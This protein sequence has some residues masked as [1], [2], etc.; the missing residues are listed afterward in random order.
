MNGKLRW[1]GAAF[2]EFITGDGKRILFDPWTKTDGNNGCPY[3]NDEFIN[4]DLI[5]VS[6]DHFDHIGSAASICKLSKALLGGPEESLK[7]LCKEEG[8]TP[9]LIVNN[10][11]GYIVGGGFENEWIKVVS[12]P[13][14]HTSNTSMALGTIAILKNG[15]TLYHTGDT[16]IVAE[17]EIYGRLYPVDIVFLPVFSQCMMD[18]IQAAEAVRMINPRIAVPVHFDANK[19]PLFELNRFVELCGKRNPAVKVIKTEK[20]KWYDLKLLAAKHE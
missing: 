18:Y 1:L 2:I 9:D 6:H 15:P 3:A 10:G 14:H 4:T 13:A 19:D 17:M 11:G 12:A 5:L 16:S 20:N 8:L 7:R